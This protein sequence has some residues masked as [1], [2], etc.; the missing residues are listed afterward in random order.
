MAK[1]LQ[2]KR[3]DRKLPVFFHPK[4]VGSAVMSED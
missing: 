3:P 4:F 2:Q 1:G